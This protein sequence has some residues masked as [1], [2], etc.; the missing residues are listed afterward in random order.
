MKTNFIEFTIVRPDK[1]EVFEVEWIDVQ[2]PAGS[3]VV[4]L[5]HLPLITRLKIRGE[6]S[7]KI[8]DGKIEKIETYGGYF[9]IESNKAIA[10]LEL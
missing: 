1:S 3:F 5:N 9:K 8:K 7:F 10:V 6:L 2:S 4:G